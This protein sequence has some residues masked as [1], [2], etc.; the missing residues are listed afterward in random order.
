[1]TNNS[2]LYVCDSGFVIIQPI[3]RLYDIILEIAPNRNI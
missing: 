1:M 3:Q 2:I